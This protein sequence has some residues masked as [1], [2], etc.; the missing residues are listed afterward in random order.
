MPSGANG[1][2]VLQRFARVNRGSI[3]YGAQARRDDH[4]HHIGRTSWSQTSG[5]SL[6]RLLETEAEWIRQARNTTRRKGEPIDGFGHVRPA[7]MADGL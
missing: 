4:G 6:D 2:Q 3:H 5:I 1:Y 7:G